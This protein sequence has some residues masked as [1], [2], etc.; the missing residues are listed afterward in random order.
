M[1]VSVHPSGTMYFALT[2]VMWF[3]DTYRWLHS[4]QRYTS[5]Q[6]VGC[7][8]NPENIWVTQEDNASGKYFSWRRKQGGLS[9]GTM[10]QEAGES[11]RGDSWDELFPSENPLNQRLTSTMKQRTSRSSKQ[12]TPTLSMSPHTEPECI[13]STVTWPKYTQLTYWLPTASPQKNTNKK[14]SQ[15]F[16]GVGDGWSRAGAKIFN[17]W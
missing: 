4:R 13:S 14:T 5:V 2:K 12:A 15:N 8:N 3:P 1:L 6:A 7:Q 9:L 17:I 10:G 11:A 16:A